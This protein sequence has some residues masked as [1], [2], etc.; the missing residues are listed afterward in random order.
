MRDKLSAVNSNPLMRVKNAV[1]KSG[2]INAWISQDNLTN[3]QKNIDVFPEKVATDVKA[4]I[5]RLRTNIT[6]D[7]EEAKKAV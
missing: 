7:S 5:K 1:N 3:L 6:K 2:G 4:R